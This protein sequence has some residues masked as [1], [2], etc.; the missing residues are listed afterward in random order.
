VRLR[1]AD[2]KGVCGEEGRGRMS[3]A[4]TAKTAKEEKDGRG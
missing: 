3:L 1:L 2:S 4:K